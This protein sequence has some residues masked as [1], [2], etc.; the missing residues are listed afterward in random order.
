MSP[1]RL[2]VAAASFILTVFVLCQVHPAEVHCT[3]IVQMFGTFGLLL[4]SDVRTTTKRASKRTDRKRRKVDAIGTK[5]VDP[6]STKNAF[7]N[8]K[9]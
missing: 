9:G 5:A 7:D 6:Q 8:S 4:N 1:L 2:L 3:A